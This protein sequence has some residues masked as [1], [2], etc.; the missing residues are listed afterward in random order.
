MENYPLFFYLINYVNV[1]ILRLVNLSQHV[2]PSFLENKL[3]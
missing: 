2:I 3:F 1:K